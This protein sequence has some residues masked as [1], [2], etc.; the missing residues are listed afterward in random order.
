MENAGERKIAKTVSAKKGARERETV[1]KE[2]GKM[3]W[4]KIK[5]IV[6][7]NEDRGG[8]KRERS[9]KSRMETN[10]RSLEMQHP[11]R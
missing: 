4:E 5:T 3:G 10:V 6:E 7:R 8:K 9:K 1:R 2:V 11:A